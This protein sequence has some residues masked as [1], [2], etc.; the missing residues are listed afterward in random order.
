MSRVHI[1]LGKICIAVT[2][3][4]V[5]RN[6]LEG[7]RQLKIIWLLTC[8][9]PALHNDGSS[10]YLTRL[11][12]CLIQMWPFYNLRM[13]VCLCTCLRVLMSVCVPCGGQRTVSGV[14]WLSKGC[15]YQ[16]YWQ[17]SRNSSFSTSHFF[18][19]VLRLQIYTTVYKFMWVLRIWTKVLILVW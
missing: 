12:D 14:L 1:T 17:A 7:Q 8:N 2:Q 9:I 18:V 13:H 11:S 15:L 10:N 4:Q 3:G 19:W 16:I 6:Y 5:M